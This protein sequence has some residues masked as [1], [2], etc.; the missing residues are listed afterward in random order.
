MSSNRELVRLE[1]LCDGVFA[2]A[3]TLLILEIKVPHFEHNQSIEELWRSLSKLWPSYLAYVTSFWS[4]LVI[5]LNHRRILKVVEDTSN[6]FDYANGFML[7][8]V[9]SFPF[10]TALVA[11]YIATPQ[12]SVTVTVF[13]SVTLLLN[14][15]FHLVWP[16]RKP[17]HL[18]ALRDADDHRG[19]PEEDGLRDRSLRDGD[20]YIVVVPDRGPAD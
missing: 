9:A 6:A 12:V 19:H 13:S 1:T 14:F 15:A 8:L 17:R 4:I 11:E 18:P 5:W 7:L 2:V 3:I 20:C 10:P 16:A